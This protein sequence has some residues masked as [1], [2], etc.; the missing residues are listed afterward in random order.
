MFLGEGAGKLYD[1][2]G[3]DTGAQ[4]QEGLALTSAVKGSS[5]ALGGF[6]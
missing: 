6:F 2:H 3:G 1:G 5:V 4:N